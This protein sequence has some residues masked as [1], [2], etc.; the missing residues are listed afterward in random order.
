MENSN[1]LTTKKPFPNFTG[2][3]RPFLLT[4][5]PLVAGTLIYSFEDLPLFQ[6]FIRNYIP[7]FLWAFSWGSC[8]L[9][10]WNGCVPTG[11]W[12]AVVASFTIFELGQMKGVIQGHGDFRDIIIYGIGLF[13]AKKAWKINQNQ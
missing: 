13:F 7:D 11:W 9:W 1:K 4:F 6:G 12:I 2:H 3:W 10:L 5:V 8:M